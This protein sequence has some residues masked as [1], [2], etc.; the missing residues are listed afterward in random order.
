MVVMDTVKEEVLNAEHGFEGLAPVRL[1]QTQQTI[2][3][4]SEVERMKWP[5]SKESQ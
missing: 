5:F 1:V 2:R 4:A 3:L